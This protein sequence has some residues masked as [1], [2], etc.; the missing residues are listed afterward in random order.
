MSKRLFTSDL[1]LGH[2]KITEFRE[3]FSSQEEHDTH[4]LEQFAQ[5]KKR[6]IVWVLGDFIF[7][8][9]RY[10]WYIQQFNK[11]SC[12]IRLSLGNHDSL[13]L[14]KEQRFDLQLPLYT[15][16][17][18]WLSH[19]P[20]HPDELRDRTANIHGHLHKYNVKGSYPEYKEVYYNVCPE[21]H[22]N[23]FVEFEQIVEYFKG[24]N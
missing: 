24:V 9:D 22:N 16:K 3:D 14:Y 7:D 23:T 2:S 13:K 4:F 10:A 1:H 21:Q 5:L 17:N 18:F 11:M 12:E 19:C 8:S 20:I 6:D 15:Y